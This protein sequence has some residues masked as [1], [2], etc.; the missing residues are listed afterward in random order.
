[1]TEEMT[2]YYAERAAEYDRVYDLPAWQPSLAEVR[3]RIAGLLAGRRVREVACGTGYWTQEIARVASAF[4]ATDL[5]DE[6][7]VLARARPWPRANVTFAREDA[8]AESAAGRTF[9]GGFAGLWLSHV[10]LARM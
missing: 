5:N 4:H 9:D 1:M 3:R 6:T 10:D 8:Y 2:R 7:L